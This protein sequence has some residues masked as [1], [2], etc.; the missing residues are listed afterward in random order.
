MCKP[1]TTEKLSKN[2]QEALEKA[3]ETVE[4]KKSITP[5]HT[6]E[7]NTKYDLLWFMAPLLFSWFTPVMPIY[8]IAFA[9]IISTHLVNGLHY[10]FVDK[11]NYLNKIPQ[12]Q[13]ERE[14]EHYLVATVL[15]MYVQG[16]LQIILPSLLF[17][18]NS[19]ILDCAKLTFWSHIIMVEPLYYFAHRWLHIPENMK[20]MHG[21]H[22]LSIRTTPSTSLVQNFE[23]HFVYVATF[24][25]AFF[26]PFLVQG[27]QHW[28]VIG[29]Y[30][31]MFD[32]VNAYGHTN[33]RIR[34]PLVTHRFSPLRY[35]LYTPEFHLGH[36]AYF[37]ANYGLFS[38]TLDMLFGT[39]REYKKPDVELKPAN[40]QDFVF[41][42]HNAGLGHLLTV[43]ELSIYNVY[44]KF[45]FKL[46]LQVDFLIMK[47]IGT[48]YRLFSKTYSVS[49][50]LVG[51]EYIG[52]VITI[53]RTPLDF[54]SPKMYPAMNKDII[55]LIKQEYKKCGTRYFG[56]GNLTKMKQLNDGG[57]VISK[58]VKQDPFLK[59]KN[60][61]IWTGDTMTAASVYNQIIDI[62]NLK[63]FFFI[64]AN[65][66]I[67]TAVCHLLLKTHPDIKVKILSRYEG[68]NF[69][70]VSYTSDM[71]EI[72][73]YK[74][75]V[76]GKMLSSH[77]YENAFRNYSK[78]AN[79]IDGCSSNKS[80]GIKTRYIL[81]Y[82]V[83]FIPIKFKTE[84]DIKHIP[85]GILQTTP[86]KKFLQGSFD[87]CMSHDENHI[88][89]CH[90]GCILNMY[91]KRETDE[92]GDI[93]IEEMGKMWK[94]ANSHGL[95]NKVIE[96]Q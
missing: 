67:G 24:G 26:V 25:P 50:Y 80:S 91:Y 65:G 35:M 88:Y 17:A 27:Y 82:T 41:I 92:V 36:H 83:P 61:R 22:H 74:I 34:N 3:T 23:E 7:R 56:L 95:R 58:M 6:Q 44:D 69:P 32:A 89:P 64:G 38:P 81:D 5:T 20:K 1:V 19:T 21:F 43:P 4:F 47:V 75:V 12:K 90:T 93:D 18:D 87:V 77:M 55:D 48:I 73:N 10:I 29:A 16:A 84:V 94:K 33:I 62:P 45:S 96:Y 37:N 52:R 76:V 28:I 51:G 30:L 63:E 59:D 9:R 15:H 78:A 68:M 2:P 70:N 13:L 46:P 42:G 66:K 8:L 39:Y 85:I 57:V 79:V 49:R 40:Q 11:D 86:S 72:V 71:N 31:V 54:L 60:I 53:V 14:R